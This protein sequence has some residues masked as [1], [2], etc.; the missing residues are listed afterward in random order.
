MDSMKPKFEFA[1]KNIFP[2]Y[3]LISVGKY[4]NVLQKRID[5]WIYMMK[6]NE[7]DSFTSRNIDKAAVKLAELNMSI[8]ERKIYE[9]YIVNS[10]RDRDAFNTA[11]NDSY[12]K[13]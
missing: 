11:M 5:E 8:N 7:I 1:E 4:P 10:V 12:Q 3:Y 13:R 2:E 9:K 6:N